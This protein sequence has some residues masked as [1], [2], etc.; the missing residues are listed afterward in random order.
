MLTGWYGRRD[1]RLPCPKHQATAAE[2]EPDPGTTFPALGRA[3]ADVV[4]PGVGHGEPDSVRAREGRGSTAS[5]G[6]RA[7]Q[8]AESRGQILSGRFNP[9]AAARGRAHS[10]TPAGSSP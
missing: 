2:P 4:Q 7:D 9:S 8:P 6:G 3:P 10:Q 1:C 5:P